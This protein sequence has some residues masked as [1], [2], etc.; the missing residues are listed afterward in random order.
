MPKAGPVYCVH[1]GPNSVLSAILLK[2]N[3][4]TNERTIQ[5]TPWMFLILISLQSHYVYAPITVFFIM[6]P[7]TFYYRAMPYV[8][9]GIAMAS[10]PSI[11]P[12][13]CLSVWVVVV[14]SYSLG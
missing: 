8:Q 2:F 4:E 10:R 14:Y 6:Y 5:N 11:C 7:C 3:E 1:L 13:L 9:R 12:S